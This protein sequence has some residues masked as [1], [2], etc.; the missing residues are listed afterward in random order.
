MIESSEGCI[1]DSVLTAARCAAHTLLGEEEVI[2]GV[3]YVHIDSMGL[4]IGIRSAS[5]LKSAQHTSR[6]SST[7]PS[8]IEKASLDDL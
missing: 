7:T 6:L 5:I 2:L 1:L 4:V 3:L 8:M